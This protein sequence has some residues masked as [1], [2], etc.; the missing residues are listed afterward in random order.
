MKFFYVE[1][2]VA[3]GLGARTVLDRSTHPPKVSRLHYVIDGW[4]GDVL[5]ESFPC[6]AVTDTAAQVI[7]R[8]N[9]AGVVFD[10]MEVTLSDV[11]RDMYPERILPNFRWLKPSGQAGYADFGTA[12]DGRLVVS[13]RALEILLALGIPNA[14]ITENP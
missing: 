13:E 5:I 8:H 9:L 7:C 14:L 10:D 3:G 12:E 6:F 4:L 11:F 1:P 2:E